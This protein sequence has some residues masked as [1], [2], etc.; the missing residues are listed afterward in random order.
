MKTTVEWLIE[1]LLTGDYFPYG[2]PKKLIEMATKM[3][4]EQIVN[5]WENG[6]KSTE[7]KAPICQRKT[8]NGYFNKTFK[9]INQ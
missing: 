3:E 7:C 6:K 9:N 8:G 4:K 1:E 5:A 2:I